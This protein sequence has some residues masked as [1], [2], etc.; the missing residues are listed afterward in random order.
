M[1]SLPHHSLHANRRTHATSTL[2]WRGGSVATGHMSRL[3][4]SV[5]QPPPR[6]DHA[7]APS[8][9]ARSRQNGVDA[10]RKG[11][12]L[13]SPLLD[14]VVPRVYRANV[15]LPD[16]TMPLSVDNPRAFPPRPLSGSKIVGVPNPFM[17][18]SSSKGTE[19]SAVLVIARVYGNTHE[20]GDVP[21][22]EPRLSGTPDNGVV[23][24]SRPRRDHT[25]M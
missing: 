23:H 22:Y 7:G 25:H 12:A 2:S 4:G 20:G 5:K 6:G 21:C 11:V 24:A 14:G 13:G 8:I 18:E 9:S 3:C 16:G 19:T 15:G 1:P 17:A 10:R